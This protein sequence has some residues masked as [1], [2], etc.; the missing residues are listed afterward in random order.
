MLLRPQKEC[1]SGESQTPAPTS[2]S[3]YPASQTS[4]S[5]NGGAKRVAKG[6]GKVKK[7][8]FQRLSGLAFDLHLSIFKMGGGWTGAGP[9]SQRDGKQEKREQKPER[10]HRGM[11]RARDTQSQRTKSKSL[12]DRSVEVQWQGVRD[13]NLSEPETW[14]RR[15]W[16][17]TTQEAEVVASSLWTCLQGK[18]WQEGALR[19]S[20]KAGGNE[21]E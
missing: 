9:G 20:W 12:R 5:A 8:L 3:V 19:E 14:V 6:W 11:E 16:G 18:T 13:R 4:S 15:A 21:L 1:S 10:G 17:Q 7:R 2:V